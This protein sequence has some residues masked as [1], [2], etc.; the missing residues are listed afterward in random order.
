VGI[1]TPDNEVYLIVGEHKPI[2]D[3]LAPLAAKTITVEG[4]VVERNGM[5]MIENAVI[6]S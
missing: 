6:E 3:K 4:K 5:K 1:L 2:N